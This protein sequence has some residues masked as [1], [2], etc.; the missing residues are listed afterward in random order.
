MGDKKKRRTEE[1]RQQVVDRV[2]TGASADMI[3][4]YR[5]NKLIR[6]GVI[7]KVADWEDDVI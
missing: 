6:Q 1:Y 4:E 3:A 5:F 2:F 7:C